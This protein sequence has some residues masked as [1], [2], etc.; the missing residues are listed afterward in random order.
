MLID[1]SDSIVRTA[2]TE[3]SFLKDLVVDSKENKSAVS[4]IYVGV[5]KKIL[6]SQFVFLDIGQE[7]NAFLQLN[8]HKESHLI[9]VNES[10]KKTVNL[11]LGQELVVQVTKDASG[12]KGACVT[13]QLS[14]TGNYM[15]LMANAN[16]LN[17][18]VSKKIASQAERARLKNILCGHLPEGYGVILRTRCENREEPELVSELN[19]LIE[20]CNKTLEKAKYIKGSL[21]VYKEGFIASK[22]I[23]ELYRDDIDEVII[24][25][26]D[27]YLNV[28]EVIKSLSGKE[29]NCIKIHKEDVLL[30]DYYNLE[31]T[32]EK[33]LHKRVWL[34]SG[35]F[36]SIEQT[37]AC[38]VIDVNTGKFEGKRN[39]SDTI[40]KTNIEASLEICNQIRLRNLSGMVIIDF[41]DMKSAEDRNTLMLSMISELK[42]DRISTTVFGMT[43]L[44]LVQLTRKKTR[45]PISSIL[46]KECRCCSGT[47]KV[48]SEVYIADKIYKLVN[49]IFSGTVYNKLTVRAN[50]N[51]I[52]YFTGN[53]NYITSLQKKF[54]KEINFE[55]IDTGRLEYFEIE[56]EKI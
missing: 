31:N 51:I 4:N 43:K 45:E 24:N 36:L 53:S 44:G 47:G 52:Y 30:F 25:N 41:I 46:Q 37:D 6:P 48:Q 23:R 55:P 3:D 8:D 27:E 21:P 33:L 14:F 49:N 35:G 38:V 16:G 29:I 54:G 22:A 40:L 42:R 10:G 11:R 12:T 34:K 18:G 5:V 17:I 28:L 19:K 9:S 32:I 20:F 39:H 2:L 15:I 7:K 1:F 13:S 56:K 26:E 50:K